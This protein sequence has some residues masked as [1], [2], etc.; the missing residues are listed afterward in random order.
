LDAAPGGE[1]R[2]AY[3]TFEP[4]GVV[5]AITPFNFPFNLV[6]HKVGPAIASGNTVVLKPA[7]QTPLSALF[8]AE[9][10][11]EAG[12]PDGA[13]NVVTGSRKNDRGPHRK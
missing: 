6:A 8:I 9:L 13:L 3:T 11:K 2:F 4:L 5:G 12:L 1:G 10:A 7:A